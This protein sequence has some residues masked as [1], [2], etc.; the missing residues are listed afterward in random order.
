VEALNIW[1]Q[2]H[3]SID[4]LLTDLVMP[5]GMTGLEL[6][7]RLRSE[8]PHLKVIYASG[9]SEQAVGKDLASRPDV[10]YLPKPYTPPILLQ[11]V[12]ACL[13]KA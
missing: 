9:Y 2:H 13:D 6:A 7:E 1:Q 12:R 8:K 3:A 10:N 11:A 4:L 5:G